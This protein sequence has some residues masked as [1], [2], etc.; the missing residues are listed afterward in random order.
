MKF[1]ITPLQGKIL[2]EAESTLSFEQFKQ[3]VADVVNPFPVKKKHL[4]RR[5]QSSDKLGCCHEK[6]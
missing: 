1:L 5:H 6:N 4:G 3:V 2:A